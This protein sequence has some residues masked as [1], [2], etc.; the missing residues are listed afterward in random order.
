MYISKVSIRN[1]R[2]FLNAKFIFRKGINTIIGE[3][4]S[5]K[6]TLLKFINHDLHESYVKSIV[7][8]NQLKLIN[9]I[10]SEKVKYI[11]QGDIIDKFN[12]KTLF[13]SKTEINFK[14]IE[15]TEF[16]DEYEHFADILKEKIELNIRKKQAIESLPDKIINYNPEL[17]INNYFIHVT[18]PRRSIGEYFTDE[19]ALH[20]Y[21][22]FLR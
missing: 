17:N 21:L 8:K 3:N 14:K 2:N 12:K 18:C 11:Q 4:G 20:I 6:S 10:E 19:D 9:N 7:S 13:T 5:G 15:H 22:V 16:Q 1:Y